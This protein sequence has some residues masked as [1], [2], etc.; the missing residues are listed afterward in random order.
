MRLK[1]PDHNK[2]VEWKIS[3]Q[4][5]KDFNIDYGLTYPFGMEYARN[6]DKSNK[7]SLTAKLDKA[8]SN[9]AIA[10]APVAEDADSFEIDEDIDDYS[11]DKPFMTKVKTILLVLILVLTYLFCIP[12]HQ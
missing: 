3:L 10:S 7:S 2:A 1:F 12:Y 8:K 5:W 9:K 11:G 6:Q 4:D